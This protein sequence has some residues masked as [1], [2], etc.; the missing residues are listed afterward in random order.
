[1]RGYATT[2]TSVVIG[3]DA[4]L[5]L[6]SDSLGSGLRLGVGAWASLGSSTVFG[7]RGL[8]GGVWAFSPGFLVAL[9]V[10]PGIPLN[11]RPGNDTDGLVYLFWLVSVSLGFEFKL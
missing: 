4:Y 3:A 1:M 11:F 6:L 10:R 9:E 5:R 2:F 8:L 7:I